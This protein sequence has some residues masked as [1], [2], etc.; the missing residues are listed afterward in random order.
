MS[1]AS[2]VAGL[3]AELHAA[4]A[5]AERGGGGAPSRRLRMRGANSAAPVRS[6]SPEPRSELAA[7]H[8][9]LERKARA[10]KKRARGLQGGV[11]DEGLVDW[12]VKS[13]ESESDDAPDA[14]DAPGDP[15]DNDD[16]MVEYTDEFGRTRTARQS[17][18]PRTLLDAHAGDENY[19]NAV[20]GPATSFPVYHREPRTLDTS[21]ADREAVHFDADRDI[22]A[23]GAAFY[24]FAHDEPT[25]RA[26][27]AALAE[28]RAETI[29]A[30]SQAAPSASSPGA[31]RRAERQRIIDTHR[32]RRRQQRQH[33]DAPV[34]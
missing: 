28:R 8:A 23:R 5:R 31:E 27:Q 30:R 19:D 24:K 9:A 25:R 34:R 17:D 6:A 33:A 7:S 10:Y 15:Y 14:P 4:R 29:H 1:A 13:V 11:Y 12:D 22:R 18:V 20:Y 3:R 2:S 26:Q 16:P 21:L 32:A